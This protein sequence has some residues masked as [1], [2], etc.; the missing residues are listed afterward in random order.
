MSFLAKGVDGTAH[1]VHCADG[2]VEACMVG[3]WV[4]EVG[5]S[6]LAYA[7]QSLEVGVVDQLVN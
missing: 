4:D 7:A 3:P 1:E 6:Q 5:Q 2:V